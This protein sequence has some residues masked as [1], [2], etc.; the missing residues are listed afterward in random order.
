MVAVRSALFLVLMAFAVVIYASALVVLGGVLGIRGRGRI[1]RSWARLT[2]WLLERLCGLGYRVDGC[3]NLPHQACLVFCKHQSAW[4]TIALRAL[5]PLEQTWVLK[6][7]LMRVPFFGWALQ[8]YQPIAIDRSAGRQAIRH[9]LKTGADRLAAGYWV[10]IF[11]EGTRVAPGQVK[12]FTIGGA[13]LAE[14]T[15]ARVVP[16]A[17]NAGVFWRR[18]SLRKFPGCIELVIGP[19]I[20]TQSKTAAEINAAAEDWINRTVAALPGGDQVSSAAR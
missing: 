4:E 6:Q 14:R 1:G 7:E 15:A 5:L 17:H 11:P 16:I 8:R 12:R 13:L 3:E 18:R 9:L 20:E 2:L 19:A 10:V